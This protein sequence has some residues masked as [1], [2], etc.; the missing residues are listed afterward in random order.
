MNSETSSIIFTE[1]QIQ[2][3]VGEL[4]RSISAWVK[5]GHD[6]G[7]NLVSVLEGVRLFTR[8]LV[9]NLKELIPE[10]EI[11]IHEVR[12]KGTDGTFRLKTRQ[13]QGSFPN[14]QTLIPGPILL[15]DDLVDSGMTLQMLRQ[16]LENLP[17]GEIKTAVLIRK[18]GSAGGPVDFCGCELGLSEES[19]AQKGLKDYWLF[20]YGM[21]LDGAQRELKY[22]GWI[23]IR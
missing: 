12:V 10:K 15:V 3:A 4:S 7:L 16:E 17:S 11:Q 5:E 9:E 20:G 2:L 22:I 1:S 13:K 14:R 19:L 8:D 6:A 18:F 21:D 23:E